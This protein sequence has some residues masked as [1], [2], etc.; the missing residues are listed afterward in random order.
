MCAC[1]V[2]KTGEQLKLIHFIIS[3]I[4]IEVHVYLIIVYYINIRFLH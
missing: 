3:I 2:V 1:L 4:I